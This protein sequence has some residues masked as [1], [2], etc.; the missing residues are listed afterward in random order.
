MS[1]QDPNPPP[2]ERTLAQRLTRTRSFER[3]GES[4]FVER[5]AWHRLTGLAAMGGLQLSVLALVAEVL[6]V[7]DP[8][9]VP[10]AGFAGPLVAGAV[11][12]ALLWHFRSRRKA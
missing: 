11:C 10:S 2:D 4:P 6:N 8:G 9:L 5:P 1:T 3:T 12:A 7:L